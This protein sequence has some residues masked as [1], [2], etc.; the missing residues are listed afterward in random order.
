MSIGLDKS[1]IIGAL[2]EIQKP[3]AEE[4]KP[5]SETV[6]LDAAEEVEAVETAPEKET[7]EDVVETSEDEVEDEGVQSPLTLTDIAQ[8]QDQELDAFLDSVVANVTVDGQAESKTLRE[9]I[10]DHQSA[11]SSTRRFEEAQRLTEQSKQG[12]ALIQQRVQQ[13]DGVIQQAAAIL[14]GE[15]QALES[16]YNAIN[17][18]ELERDEPE[19]FA[20]QRIRFIERA[21]QIQAKQQ[22]I[23]QER[24]PPIESVSVHGQS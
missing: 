11:K 7:T 23:G 9:I 17:W 2:N 8:A 6:A 22:Q 18:G 24:Q 5:E 13:L 19:R 4:A 15:Q 20:A 16:E 3:A 14:N 21:Q 10:R 1:A 12:E